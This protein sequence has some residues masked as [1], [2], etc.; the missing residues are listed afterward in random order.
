MTTLNCFKAYDVRGIINEE[1]DENITYRIGRSIAQHFKAK[2]IV[3][4][5]DSRAVVQ[6]MLHFLT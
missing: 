2:S 3:V 6:I 1:I 5:F 4:G